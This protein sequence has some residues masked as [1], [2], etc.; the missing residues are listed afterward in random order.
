MPQVLFGGHV[1][2]EMPVVEE[3][4]T[5]S[6]FEGAEAMRDDERCTILQVIAQCLVDYTFGTPIDLARRLI[7][8]QDTWITQQGAS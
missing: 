7:E 5:I 4:N 1:A 8:N 3:Q 2:H 6:E